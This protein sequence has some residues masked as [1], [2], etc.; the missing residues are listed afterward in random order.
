MGNT[1]RPLPFSP[2][3]YNEPSISSAL[4]GVPL[5]PDNIIRGIRAADRAVVDVLT[6]KPRVTTEVFKEIGPFAIFVLPQTLIV[7]TFCKTA[8]VVGAFGAETLGLNEKFARYPSFSNISCSKEDYKFLKIKHATAIKKKIKFGAHHWSLILTIKLRDNFF[9][10]VLLQK[11]S[12]GLIGCA[13]YETFSSAA[14][15]TYGENPYSKIQESDVDKN[16]ASYFEKYLKPFE[17]YRF[18]TNDC[19]EFVRRQFKNLTG[20]EINLGM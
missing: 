7:D 16:W 18:A 6:D 2:F 10:Y 19:Q 17:F 9:K 11:D 14:D 13:S 15:A 8:Q 20:Y 3:H 12:S 1:N 4:F 5:V